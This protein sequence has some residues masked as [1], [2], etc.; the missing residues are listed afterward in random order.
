MKLKTYL[1]DLDGTMYRG[2]SNIDGAKEFIDDCL[3]KKIPFYFLTNNATRTLRQNVE[4]MEKLGF[5]GIQENQFFTSSM[6]ACRHMAKKGYKKAQYIGM[7]GLKEALMSSHF[8]ISEHPECVF[9]GLDKEGTYEK[10]TQALQY[11]LEGAILVGTNDDRLLAHGNT[12]YVGNG[13]IVRMFEYATGQTSLRIGKPSGVILQE[14]LEYYHLNKEDC[15]LVGDNLETDIALGVNEHVETV[16]V[17][18]GVHSVDDIQRL[19]IHP[20]RIIQRLDELI[21]K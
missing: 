13:S 10:Y 18:S 17:T 2:D 21:E 4:H 9:I 5:Q 14:A 7:D 20:D 8:E 15:I 16:L 19:N 11:L 6:A 3:K 12:Y 1:I